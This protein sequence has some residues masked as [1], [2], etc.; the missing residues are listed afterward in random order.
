MALTKVTSAVIKD[1][2]ITDADIGSTLT[3]AIT[4]SFTS[5]SSSIATRFDSRESDMT[6]ATASISAI[7][8]SISRLNDEISTDD[9]DMTLATASIAAITASIS[10]LDTEAETNES[11]MTLATASIAAITSSIADNLDQAVKQAS[12]VT[13]ATVD[14]GQGANEL[15]DMDQNVKTDSDVTFGDINSTGTITAV[16]IHTTFVSSSITVASG[17]NNFGDALDDHHSFT[18]SLSISGSGTITGSF[19]VE[20]P[21]TIDE[22]TATSLT[23]TGNIS[24]SIT[25]TGSFARFEA[26]KNIGV[27]TGWAESDFAARTLVLG[28]RPSSTALSSLGFDSGGTYKCG[29]DF[30][31]ADGDWRLYQYNGSSYVNQVSFIGG[32]SV[33]ADTLVVS[34]SAVGVDGLLTVN[35]RLN[36]YA[37][38]GILIDAAGDDTIPT[39]HLKNTTNGLNVVIRLQNGN[40]DWKIGSSISYGN[41]FD[42]KDVTAGTTPFTIAESTGIATFIGSVSMGSTVASNFQWTPTLHISGSNPGFILADSDAGTNRGSDFYSHSV[43]SETTNIF[44]PT[45]Q[46]KLNLQ[47]AADTGGSSAATLLFVSASGHVGIGTAAPDK[48]LHLSAGAGGGSLR[49]E[50]TGTALTG[51]ANGVLGVIEFEGQ[52]ATTNASGVRASITGGTQNTSGGAYLGFSTGNSATANAEKMRIQANG[53]VGIGTDVPEH[54]LHVYT[55][56]DDSA[57]AQFQNHHGSDPYGIYINWSN[58]APNGTGTEYF[59][60]GRDTEAFEFHVWADGSFVTTSDRRRKENITDSSDSLD[61]VN[62]LRVVDYTRIGDTDGHQHIGLISQEVKEIYPHLISVADDAESYGEGEEGSQMLYKIGMIPLLVKSVQELTQAHRDLRA[63][64]TG[65]TDINQ[66]KA[67]VTGSTFA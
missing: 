6:L 3:T 42:I 38:G 23:A 40:Q 55:A 8:A 57:T 36:S 52:D 51:D 30:D 37:E 19:T 34:G 11:N 25:S 56:L 4:G 66:L 62:Q 15:Y 43:N 16:E 2:T 29:I 32:A 13:F 64:I 44:I 61:K 7:T 50:N 46:G 45:S 14:T 47:R 60:A 27:G 67:L 48:Q 18:G 9:T 10:R 1:A 49:F 28:G 39:L 41:N 12:A 65:S 63:Q 35:P 24:S 5:V 31:S 21:S 22:L 33:S 54:P 26:A 20:G 17:S 59:I 53:N 58:A